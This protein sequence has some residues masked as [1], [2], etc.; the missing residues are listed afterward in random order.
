MTCCKWTEGGLRGAEGVLGEIVQILMARGM[1]AL[2]HLATGTTGEEPWPRV[3]A[4][5]VLRVAF[6][7]ASLACDTSAY[8]A[9]GEQ[10][11]GSCWSE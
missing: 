3:H 8:Y 5:N 10:Q 1:D 6:N 7:D 11:Q 4:L 2:L 9:R